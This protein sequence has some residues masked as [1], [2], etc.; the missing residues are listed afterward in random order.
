[1]ADLLT[2]QELANAAARRDMPAVLSH[3]LAVQTRLA[4]AEYLAI[5]AE[6]RAQTAER[7]AETTQRI[8]DQISQENRDL[9]SAS[10]AQGSHSHD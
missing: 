2:V 8:M 3:L 9:R 5:A 10:Q 6:A 4:Q 7:V 1:M